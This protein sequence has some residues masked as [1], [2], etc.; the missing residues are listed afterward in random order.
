MLSSSIMN[1]S[2]TFDEPLPTVTLFLRRIGEIFETVLKVT[3]ISGECYEHTDISLAD[4]M[5]ICIRGNSVS[6]RISVDR[7]SR[8]ENEWR[9]AKFNG[10]KSLDFSNKVAVPIDDETPYPLTNLTPIS[11]EHIHA[12]SWFPATQIALLVTI[13]NPMMIH[14]HVHTKDHS[15]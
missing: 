8:E 14:I 15:L 12:I 2:C 6:C 7:I 4:V 9:C 10:D 1:I 11:D 3:D 13:V 5:C